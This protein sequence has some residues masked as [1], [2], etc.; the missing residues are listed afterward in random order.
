MIDPVLLAQL[1]AAGRRAVMAGHVVG[2]GGN[3]S[4]RVRADACLITAA[5]AALDEL[6]IGS[7]VVVGLDGAVRDG[8]AQPSSEAAVHLAAYNARPDIGAVVHLHPRTAVVLHALGLE[9]GLI[10][11][12]HAFYVRSIGSVPFVPPGTAEVAEAVAAQ[13]ARHD[14]VMIRQHGCV[15]VGATVALAAARAAN[16][17]EAA[18]A[19]VLALSLGDAPPAVPAAWLAQLDEGGPV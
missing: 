12:D 15:T 13:L 11:T 19:T 10:T 18:R 5:G 6:E 3:L 7:V 1:A 14:V 17:E 2:T 16:L 9:I 8:D 4:A